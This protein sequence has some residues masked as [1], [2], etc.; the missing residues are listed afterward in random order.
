MTIDLFAQVMNNAVRTLLILVLPIIGLG[1]IVGFTIA[2]F[3]AL[4]QIQEQTLTFVPKMV[5]V[6]LMV[7]LTSAWIASM[8]VNFCTELWL[9][10]PILR[11]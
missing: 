11:Y 2:L 1:L 9:M 4:T 10:I 8:M 6:M 3:Q 5:A 7:G